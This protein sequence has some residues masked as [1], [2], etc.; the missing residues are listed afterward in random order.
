MIHGVRADLE[1]IGQHVGKVQ[2]R[3]VF[4]REGALRRVVCENAAR[5]D[6]TRRYKRG[7]RKTASTQD[8]AA[9]LVN[10]AVAIVEVDRDGGGSQG[11]MLADTPH[12]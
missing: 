1:A 3:E 2:L 4:E 10:I 9:V 6:K 8:P 7:P 5:T 11:L 12:H